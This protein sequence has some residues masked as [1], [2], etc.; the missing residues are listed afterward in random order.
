[1]R[2]AEVEAEPEEAEMRG[3]QVMTLQVHLF[4]F[5]WSS[6]LY[7]FG[8]RVLHSRSVVPSHVRVWGVKKHR[9]KTGTE[10][11]EPEG[12]SYDL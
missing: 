2:R 5:S 3:W 10:E 8:P 11:S 7:F 12:W 6:L 1:M 4:S 9:R